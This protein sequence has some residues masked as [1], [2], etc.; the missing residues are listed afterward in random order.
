MA[1]D[2]LSGLLRGGYFSS[3]ERADLSTRH[4]PLA[5]HCGD[6][7]FFLAELAAPDRFN[8]STKKGIACDAH[9]H[10]ASA[11][12]ADPDFDFRDTLRCDPDFGTAAP[13]PLFRRHRMDL[14]GAPLQ[15]ANDA[16]AS[17]DAHIILRHRSQHWP[18]G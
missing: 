3:F 9:G 15:L 16:R 10:I 8:F 7:S 13:F 1:S 17:L 11:S 12:K 4:L 5:R 6:D 14:H 2:S 18:R